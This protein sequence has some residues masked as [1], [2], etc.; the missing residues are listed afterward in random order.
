MTIQ[1]D[2]SDE[3]ETEIDEHQRYIV[4]NENLKYSKNGLNVNKDL[5][6][7]V[8]DIKNSKNKNDVNQDSTTYRRD[9]PKLGRNDICPCGSQKKYKHCHGKIS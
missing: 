5:T 1:I 4:E 6:N 9:L 2:S 7:N 8:N 3:A